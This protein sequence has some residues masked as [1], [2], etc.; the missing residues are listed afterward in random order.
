VYPKFN[1]LITLCDRAEKRLLVCGFKSFRHE[2]V[3]NSTISVM[4]KNGAELVGHSLK[5]ESNRALHVPPTLNYNIKTVSIC[6][7]FRE[8][9]NCN[10]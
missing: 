4:F 10:N 7:F 6:P 3:R 9:I 2:S 1:C 5:R 8:K